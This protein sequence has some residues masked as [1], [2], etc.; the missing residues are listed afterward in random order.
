MKGDFRCPRLIFRQH[1]MEQLDKWQGNG[2]RIILM[3]DANENLQHGKL[4]RDLMKIGI[5]DLVR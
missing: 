3:I 5:R 4:Q 2:D 1:L